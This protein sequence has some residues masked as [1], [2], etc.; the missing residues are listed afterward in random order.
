MPWIA[1]RFLISWLQQPCALCWPVFFRQGPEVLSKYVALYAAHLIKESKTPK[2]L[3][4]FARYGT[5]AK[6]Q[7]SSGSTFLYSDILTR[8]EAVFCGVTWRAMH[9]KYDLTWPDMTLGG[10]PDVTR[11]DIT[12]VDL[13]DTC[14][15]W[16]WRHMTCVAREGVTW[17]NVTCRDLTCVTRLLDV[18]WPYVSGREVIW[19]DRHD[20]TWP[21]VAWWDG[22]G[23]DARKWRSARSP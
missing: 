6:V 8:F 13:L 12:R 18:S 14:H 5:P 4:L 22:T 17:Y 10:W 19:H 16:T 2:A 23:R 20:V 11:H 1:T 9:E 7:V 3:D 21:D 15:G